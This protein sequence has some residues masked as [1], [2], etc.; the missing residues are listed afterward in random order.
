MTGAGSTGTRRPRSPAGDRD[1]IAETP[2]RRPGRR[3]APAASPDEPRP[4]RPVAR[5]GG[6]DPEWPHPEAWLRAPARLLAGRPLRRDRPRASSCARWP[7]A[8]GSTAASAYAPVVERFMLDGQTARLTQAALE[9][10]AIVAYRQ[11]VTRARVS[12]IRGVS[13]D[14]VM[15]PCSPRG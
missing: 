2:L 6:R 9:T 3:A 7:A 4:S 5:A 13:V 8:G 14:A 15:R 1:R 11:P 12:A 10:L